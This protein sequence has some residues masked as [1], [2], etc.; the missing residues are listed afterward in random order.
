MDTAEKRY[1]LA[2]L[3]GLLG[4]F[5]KKSELSEIYDTCIILQKTKRVAKDD[6]EGQ[7]IYFG[8]G[9]T[10]EYDKLF[11]SGNA[12]TPIYNDSA[13]LLERVVYDE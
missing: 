9:K 8:D 12:I 5:V 10:P 7:L 11:T 13:E 1:T 4:K 2:D 6:L 3:S